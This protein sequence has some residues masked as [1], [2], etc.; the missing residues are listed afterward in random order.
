[1]REFSR[2]KFTVVKPLDVDTVNKLFLKHGLGQAAFV[3]R[4][5]TAAGLSPFAPFELRAQAPIYPAS[6]MKTALALAVAHGLAAGELPLAPVL[7]TER[8]MTGNDAPSPLQPGYRA[9][10][11][12]L[13]DL[14]LARSDNVATNLLLDLAGRE[15]ATAVLQEY[16]CRGTALRRYLSGSAPRITD[17]SATGENE[18]PADDAARVFELIARAAVP[19]AARLRASLTGQYWNSKISAGLHPGDVFDH[20]TGDTDGVSHDGGILIPSGGTAVFVLVLYTECPSSD[21]T[22]RRIAAWM[23]DF[24]D[25]LPVAAA[26]P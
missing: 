10:V 12:E 24:R 5:V 7:V 20:K 14:M 16:G 2:E 11:W 17:P 23:R 18:H 19:F 6:M 4:S 8:V 21:E 25:V 9:G 15:R 26:A 3:L 1:M 13:L 22:D